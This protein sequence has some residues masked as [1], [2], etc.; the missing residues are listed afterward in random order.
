MTS[1]VVELCIG[2]E[3]FSIER[4]IIE[5]NG[6]NLFT[7]L[8]YNESENRFK[9]IRDEDGRIRI[10]RSPTFFP[11]IKKWMESG[12]IDLL[13][14]WYRDHIREDADFYGLDHMIRAL[15][16]QPTEDDSQLFKPRHDGAYYPSTC[17]C[18]GPQCTCDKIIFGQDGG[19]NGSNFTVWRYCC[20]G[21]MVK[22]GTKELYRMFQHPTR[23]NIYLEDRT[24]FEV[25]NM[26]FVPIIEMIRRIKM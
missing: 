10:N 11:F 7:A 15:D 22:T 23:G 14:N 13:T 25:K 8:L 6:P 19:I 16:Q 18:S 26:M 12:Q 1:S 5:S 24:T 3:T 9:V 4:S 2:S 17:P 21:V 20:G